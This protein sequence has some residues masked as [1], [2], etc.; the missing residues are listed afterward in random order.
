MGLLRENGRNISVASCNGYTV[1]KV[2]KA[3]QYLKEIGNNRRGFD[4]NRLVEMYNDIKGTKEKAAGC[5]PCAA[6][7]Y[8]NGIQN[9]A[10][11][12]ELTLINNGKCTKEDL[13]LDLIENEYGKDLHDSELDGEEAFTDI[14]GAVITV[15]PDGISFEKEIKENEEALDDSLLDEKLD[16]K[17]FLIQEDEEPKKEDIKERMAKV[18]ACRKNKKEKNA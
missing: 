14:D 9:Y 5:K 8:Y 18:R 4:V 13:D 6:T 12:G 7:K 10:Y 17:G 2:I 3:K 1:E 15:T 16:D 11:F